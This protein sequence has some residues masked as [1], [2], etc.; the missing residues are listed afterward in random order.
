MPTATI[1]Q[2]KALLLGPQADPLTVGLTLAALTT[3]DIGRLGY[4]S[5]TGLLGDLLPNGGSPDYST[6]MRWVRAASVLDGPDDP[7]RVWG[8]AKLGELAKLVTSEA[9]D[10][11]LDVHDPSGMSVR[12]LRD[13]VRGHGIGV[14]AQPDANEAH[15]VLERAIDLAYQHEH[16]G[17]ILAPLQV[18]RS[19][20]EPS[21]YTLS[22]SGNVA[23]PLVAETLAAAARVMGAIGTA[24]AAWRKVQRGHTVSI[25]PP[26]ALDEILALAPGQL[27]A[28]WASPDL[29]R[30]TKA[31][32]PV[33]HL[34]VERIQ[35]T[36]HEP[37]WPEGNAKT[38]GVFGII[39]TISQGCL[40]AA[41][42]WPGTER[43]CFAMQDGDGNSCYANWT[44]WARL[45]RP[46]NG[47]FDV[48]SNGLVNDLMKIRIPRDGDP[49]LER[50]KRD[51]WRVD[52]ESTDGA[53]SV[54]LGIFQTLAE[55]NPTH[56][57]FTLCSHAVRPSDEMLCWLGALRNCWVGTTVAG[58][59]SSDELDVRFG[60]IER[61]I[62]FGI[63]CVV[64]V[65]THETWN[66]TPPLNRAL[67]LVPPERI[68]EAPY[69]Y[70]TDSQ[71]LPLLNV[72]P[73][74]SCSDRRIDADDIEYRVQWQPD[75]DSGMPIARLLDEVGHEPKRPPHSKCE[76]CSLLCGLSVLDLPKATKRS[77][78]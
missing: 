75:P 3:D 63:P 4:A 23:D 31:G 5:L 14:R 6:V 35:R 44:R 15:R 36:S 24:K 62:S 21:D 16:A 30:I 10:A 48:A 70:G 76:G 20:S 46:R 7:R 73:L 9:L 34:P 56:R 69:R 61:F 40:R 37:V 72:N 50:Y 71:D 22:V 27:Q 54:A 74:G 60:A 29:V 25:P 49:S 43:A 2:L 65:V 58:W 39:D 38:R 8:L 28:E 57:L 19:R 32:Q 52:A 59:L 18:K 64:W 68:I 12:E 47:G 53:L 66:N 67:E 77:P 78:S 51:Q 17:G 11:F 13:S 55:S 42:G 33:L 41:T 45:E 26:M 1:P